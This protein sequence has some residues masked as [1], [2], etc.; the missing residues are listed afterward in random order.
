MDRLLLLNNFLH[1]L[2]TGTWLGIFLVLWRVRVRLAAL[3][4]VGSHVAALAVRPAL[5]DLFWW[6]VGTLAVIL[7]TGAVRLWGERRWGVEGSA[8]SPAEVLLG[9][10]KNTSLSSTSGREG[11][12]SRPWRRERARLL[13]LKHVLLLA[14]FAVGTYIE[15]RLARGF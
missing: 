12:L 3:G 6:G 9:G 1:D 10:R 15:Y 2:A 13:I 8:F 11:R 5:R 4:P 7:A 14:G